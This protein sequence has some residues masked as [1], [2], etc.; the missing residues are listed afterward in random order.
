MGP[1]WIVKEEGGTYQL[2]TLFGEVLPQWAN[3][4]GL[5]PYYGKLPPN[6]FRPTNGS[7]GMTENV[8]PRARNRAAV[9]RWQEANEIAPADE[10]VQGWRTVGTME[11]LPAITFRQGRGSRCDRIRRTDPYYVDSDGLESHS[12]IFE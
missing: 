5:K 3:R 8:P 4:F 1:Y 6:P 2:G 12:K 9:T 10:I 11:D 7:G